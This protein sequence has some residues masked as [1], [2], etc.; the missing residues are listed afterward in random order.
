[1]DLAKFKSW[2]NE[3]HVAGYTDMYRGLFYQNDTKRPWGES[4]I[5]NEQTVYF[6]GKT[7]RPFAICSTGISWS[8]GKNFG[9][10]DGKIE[11]DLDSPPQYEARR[12]HVEGRLQYSYPIAEDS[13]E[14]R[15][16]TYSNC[17]G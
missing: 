3:I 12:K 4:C 13:A 8:A 11:L 17:V 14:D 16:L 10:T 7:R 6:R 9:K 5:L 2:R 1:M 15:L